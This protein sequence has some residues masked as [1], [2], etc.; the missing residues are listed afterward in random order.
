MLA[1]T[2]NLLKQLQKR[3]AEREERTSALESELE[4]S[5]ILLKKEQD[6]RKTHEREIEEY[7]LIEEERNTLRKKNNELASEL[8]K[9]AEKC[10]RL[11]SD[12][13]SSEQK[14]KEL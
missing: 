9:M 8:A 12:L 6:Q 1:E 5:R 3:E 13:N 10:E 7:K 11:Q 4:L 14:A 2:S